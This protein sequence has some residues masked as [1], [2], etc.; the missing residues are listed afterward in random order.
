MLELC[1]KDGCVAGIDAR[2]NRI[3]GI[4]WSYAKKTVVSMGISPPIRST[5]PWQHLQRK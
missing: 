1:E 4:G 3:E 2:L 5:L